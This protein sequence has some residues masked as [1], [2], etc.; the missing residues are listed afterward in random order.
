[1]QRI[2]DE[3]IDRR[4]TAAAR[5]DAAAAR[6]RRHDRPGARRRRAD[7][8]AGR[9]ARRR[10]GGAALPGDVGR[11]EDRAEHEGAPRVHGRPA[12]AAR[13][14]ARAA[15]APPDPPAGR[16]IGAGRCGP[17]GAVPRRARA[18]GARLAAPPRR[19]ATSD[20]RPSG[21]W[22]RPATARGCSRS[23]TA[24]SPRRSSRW[25]RPIVGLGLYMLD[26]AWLQRLDLRTVDAR[27]AV[28]DGH[29]ADPRVAL[30][31]VDD[32]T[33]EPRAGSNGRLPRSDYA[34]SSTGSG[35]TARP[36]WRST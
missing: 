31:A 21:S 6:R 19:R 3:E 9:G 30:I 26:P 34:P 29:A 15:R 17:P 36:S 4:L 28:Q 22:R 14:G 25:P 23:A 35:A 27:L 13:V 11:P 16:R 10:I 20:G 18:G 33:L 5:R 2:W 32:A 8:H 12:G 7:R 1:M 24:A